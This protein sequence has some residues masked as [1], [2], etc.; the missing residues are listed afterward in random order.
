M[1]T[2]SRIFWL[3][4]QGNSPA[5]YE[6]ACAASDAAGRYA[7]ADGA[8]EGCFTDVWARLL[9]EDFVG[10]TDCLAA[11]WPVSLSQ[12]QG[13]WD[14]DVRSREIAWHAEPWVQQG[15][16]AAFLG[17]SLTF[18]TSTESMGEQHIEDVNVGDTNSCE[19]PEGKFRQIET[20]R[21]SA[22]AIG[23]TCL[24]HTRD[25]ALLRAFPLER[26]EQFNNAPN[27]VGAR[28]SLEQIHKKRDSWTDGEGRP[29]D[30]LW[31]MTDALA[32]W[33]L[34]EVEADGNPW[35]ELELLLA[36]SA[37][38]DRF[39]PWIDRLR[40]SGRLRNDDVTLL[41]ILL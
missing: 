26:A 15:A 27:L 35:A 14:A 41:A 36:E 7:V 8:S 30:R 3:P 18:G 10:R 1:P 5:E 32:R 40:Q 38:G 37:D 33:C 31:A 22:V 24:F 39:A 28:M 17:I 12:V 6:D 20:V 11:E 19:A 4:R 29:G 23:D 13:R 2:R 21:F 9:V 34:A 25:G 16:Y